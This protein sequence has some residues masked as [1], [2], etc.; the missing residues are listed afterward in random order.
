MLPRLKPRTY[1]DLVVQVAIVRPGPI[2]GDMVHPYL[3][4]REG[5]EPV[6]YPKPELEKVLGKTLGVPLFQEQAMRVAI[7]CAGFT[8]GE[9]DML[10][11]SMA[12]FKFTGG[13]SHFR[14]KL[15]NGMVDNGYEREFAEQTFKQ[16][17][18]FGSY[19][20]PESHA[21]SFALIAYA[22]AW[23]KCWHPDIF[24]A[25]LLNSQP[26]GFYAPA[27]IVRDAQDHRVEVRP[28]CVN[29]SRWDCTLEP[30]DDDGRFAVRLG[31]RMVKGLANADAAAIVGARADT[32]FAS[33]DDLWRRAGVPVAAL[34]QIAE[35]DGFRPSLGLTRREALWA[36]KALPDEPLPLF[37]AATARE[38][39]LVPE[40][41]EPSVVLRPMTAGSEVVEDYGHVGLSLRSHPVAFLRDDLRRRRIVTCQEAME[42]RDGRWLEAAGIV[43]VRQRPGSAKG[44][45]FITLEDESGIANLV[46]W[47][48]VF[49]KHRRIILS[50]G[51][52]AV[53][54]RVQREGEVVHLVAQRLTDLSG[55]L[56]SVGDRDAAFPLPH[57]RG[58]EFH[59]GSP[60]PDPRGLAPKGLRT[61]DIYVRDL[62]IDSI[63]VKTRDFR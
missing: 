27:Q 62:H 23:L 49:E 10:R 19:G 33:V 21:A 44:V 36:I 18:G 53:R 26:M 63:K 60:T 17:E 59:H 38:Q 52:F 31:L 57:G 20:F 13:V 51:M 28:V 55:E 58:D 15:I 3:R 45:M 8:P 42:A 1:Y 54:G 41:N 2:Q 40:V 48:Q 16:F 37:V 22:S 6:D 35:G 11:K 43:L 9:A 25:A 56:A 50:A 34:V 46:V 7:E 14:D 32:F 4:R 24:C 5:L 39:Q 30:I 47:P 29:A 12:T 61:R